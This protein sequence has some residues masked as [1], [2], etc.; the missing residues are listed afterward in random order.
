MLVAP[1]APRPSFQVTPLAAMVLSHSGEYLWSLLNL[2][3]TLLTFKSGGGAEED[4][5][6]L[7]TM[8]LLVITVFHQCIV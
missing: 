5:E 1:W 4:R 6:Q 3:I 8:F 2:C 7:E